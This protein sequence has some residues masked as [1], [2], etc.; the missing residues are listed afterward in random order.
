MQLTH[1]VSQ[2]SQ[3]T[4]NTQIC[5]ISDEKIVTSIGSNPDHLME[6][7]DVFTAPQP[8]EEQDTQEQESQ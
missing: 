6:A 8:T 7:L 2:P 5:N 4:R 3:I 1:Q